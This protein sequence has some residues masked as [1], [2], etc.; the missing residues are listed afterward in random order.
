MENTLCTFTKKELKELEIYI[1]LQ[2][3]YERI[4]YQILVMQVI[5]LIIL[6]ILLDYIF[7]IQFVPK[8]QIDFDGSAPCRENIK[9]WLVRKYYTC[10]SYKNWFNSVINLTR[11]SVVLWQ[12]SKK[13]CAESHMLQEKTTTM[14]WLAKPKDIFINEKL[15]RNGLI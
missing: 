13:L 2:L 14:K 4:N 6:S 8:L 10:A 7:C 9:F 15:M 12:H 5:F 11:L 1:K 3:I